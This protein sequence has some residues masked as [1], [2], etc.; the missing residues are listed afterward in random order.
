MNGNGRSPPVFNENIALRSLWDKEKGSLRL[1]LRMDSWGHGQSQQRSGAGA[2]L[3]V[4]VERPE[5]AQ[6]VGQAGTGNASE[7]CHPCLETAVGGINGLDLPGTAYTLAPQCIQAVG[8][9]APRSRAAAPAWRCRR[10][11]ARHRRP[12]PSVALQAV[13]VSC[14]MPTISGLACT[15]VCDQGRHLLAA[16]SIQRLSSRARA[17]GICN[18]KPT[19]RSADFRGRRLTN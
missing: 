5:P 16:S 3:S 6:I 15:I 2:G 8:F 14:P 10:C 1:Q 11:R 17:A 12:S 19:G 7:A 4:P 18:P 13:R 9:Q